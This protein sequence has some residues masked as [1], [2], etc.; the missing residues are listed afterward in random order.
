M[1][2]SLIFCAPSHPTADNKGEGF[3][4]VYAEAAMVGLPVVAYAVGGALEAV[5]HGRTGKLVPERNV[6]LLA[7]AISEL[8]ANP[9]RASDLG[10]EGRLRAMRAF[11]IKKQTSRLES[12]YDEITARKNSGDISNRG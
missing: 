6:H 2:E 9:T 11:D 8:L 7:G 10:R 1:N 5:V 12:L 3:G 4:M